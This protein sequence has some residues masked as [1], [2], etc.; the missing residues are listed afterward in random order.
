MMHGETRAQ[1]PA[2]GARRAAVGDGG[3]R[4]GRIARSAPLPATDR[5]PLAAP[6]GGEGGGC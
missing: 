6:P 1:R 3:R 4:A 2:V 5:W